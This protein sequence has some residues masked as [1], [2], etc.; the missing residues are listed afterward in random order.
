VPHRF[1]WKKMN[2]RQKEILKIVSAKRRVAVKELVN[3]FGISGV[4]VRQDLTH[5]EQQGLLKRVH[6]GVTFV[7]SDD[8][9]SRLLVNFEKKLAIARK[10]LGHVAEGETVLIESGSTSAILARELARRGQVT[11]VTPNVF[12]ARECRRG[13][14]NS[15][16][17]LGGVYQKESESL[18][19]PM[20]KNCIDLV[21]VGKAFIGVDGFTRE[22]GFTSRDMMRADISSYIARKCEQLF[23]LTDSSKFGRVELVKLFDVEDVSFVI[24]DEGI[25]D[26]DRE[27][28]TGRGI[29][30]L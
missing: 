2:D 21:N 4:T 20:V 28:L 9:S 12:I 1:S 27:Y 13:D 26:Q 19:G 25:P 17:L 30:I 29:S 15:V 16:V 6:G 5:L 3:T 10:A 18:I 14:E 11:I 24:T 8:I 22:A 23:V 7:D